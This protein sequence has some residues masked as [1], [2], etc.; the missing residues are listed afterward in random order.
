MKWRHIVAAYGE[1]I[2]EELRFG[3]LISES[4]L[5]YSKET[6]KQ[7]LIEGLKEAG[8]ES[9]LLKKH[10][11]WSFLGLNQFVEAEKVPSEGPDAVLSKMESLQPGIQ[12]FGE[13]YNQMA[14]LTGQYLQGL[15]LK[16]K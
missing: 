2:L 16:T 4:K 7:A 10:L 15:R 3:F 1:V 8:Q 6:I 13:I 5:P 14:V 11:E 12:K 9:E